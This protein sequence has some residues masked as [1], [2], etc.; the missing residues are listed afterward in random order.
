MDDLLIYNSEGSDL[1]KMQLRML[2][3]L[4]FIDSICQK[5]NIQYW[6]AA[7]SLLGA[8]RH[9]GFIP[10]DDDLDIEMLKDDYK[11]LLRI[12]EKETPSNYRLQTHKSDKNYIYP[13]AKLRDTNSVISEN[14]NADKNYRY[15]GIFVD[16]FYLD[17]GNSFL[18]R[19]TVNIQ[20][21]LFVLTLIKN[22][23]FGI[24]LS[25]KNILYYTIHSILFPFLRLWARLFGIKTL[26][27]PFGTGFTK[28]RHINDIF[29]LTKI[30]FEGKYFSSP[31]NPD[32]YLKE[33]YGDYMKLPDENDR[34]VHTINLAF[35]N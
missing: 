11:K 16:I 4:I 33:L 20:K 3:M 9:G 18:A 2:E 6:L 27:L 32:A 17:R 8:V 5:Y 10:W 13:I 34:R 21:F 35:I 12:L 25:L 28:K 1:R 31:A 15:R 19:T 30:S 22:D 24:L 29:P 14:R 23:S 7:G 26:I